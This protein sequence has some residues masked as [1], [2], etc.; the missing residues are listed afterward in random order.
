MTSVLSYTNDA[1]GLTNQAGWGRAR[2]E[3]ECEYEE[4]SIAPSSQ[5][6]AVGDIPPLHRQV[7]AE[8]IVYEGNI[9]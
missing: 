4:V 3:R 9:L 2:E 5:S 7:P 8:E 6:V 1:Y